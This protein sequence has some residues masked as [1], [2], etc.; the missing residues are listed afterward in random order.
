MLLVLACMAALWGVGAA[1]HVPVRARW[2]AVGLIWLG[3]LQVISARCADTG[4]AD[5]RR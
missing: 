3:A 2:Q 1:L 5:A 4:A